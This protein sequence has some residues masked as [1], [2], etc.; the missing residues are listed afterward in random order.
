LTF[1]AG[2]S[3]GYIYYTPTV[4]QLANP[5]AAQEDCD[6]LVAPPWQKLFEDK[7]AELLGKL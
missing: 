6:C 5:G 3:N 2:Y 1:V 7:A 4:E